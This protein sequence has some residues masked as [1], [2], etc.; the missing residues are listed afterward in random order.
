M[1]AV[2]NWG[3]Q[4]IRSTGDLFADDTGN[5]PIAVVQTVALGEPFDPDRDV[6]LGVAYIS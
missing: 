2:S 1:A 3:G 4:T 6:E 5:L